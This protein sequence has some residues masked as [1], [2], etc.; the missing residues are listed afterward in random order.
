MKLEINKKYTN[1]D[2]ID[3]FG[4]NHQ[5]GI[6]IS[7]DKKNIILITK[8][9]SDNLYKDQWKGKVLYYTG[10]GQKGDQVLKGENKE[11]NDSKLNS[12]ITIH[13]FEVFKASEYTYAGTVELCGEV[14]VVEE[15][16][17]EGKMRKVYKFP[18]KL[19][20]HLYNPVQD[21]EKVTKDKRKSILKKDNNTLI[22]RAI[23]KSEINDN[24][25][26]PSYR[27]TETKSYD[28]NLDIREAAL[29]LA[30]GI[31]QL[32]DENGPFLLDGRPYLHAHHIEYLANG[33]KDVLENVI[34]VCPN[35]HEKIH[36]LELPEDKE[37]L[38]EKVKL[39]N[40]K[41]KEN[42]LV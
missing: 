8:S 37:K 41:I 34:A 4:G 17:I 30:N 14:E 24:R 2:I 39:R 23:K 12:D 31:C 15:E 35:C 9:T 25:K 13:L 10:M 6:R 36:K 38:L 21:L 26:G 20:N 42:N 27:L 40:N 5:K 7:S 32:C 11:L 28:R 3:K 16:D 18:L 33:G 29:R 22:K 1:K 19:Q